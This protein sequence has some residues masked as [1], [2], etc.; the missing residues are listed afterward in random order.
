MCANL[1]Q[2]TEEQASF[3]WIAPM[4]FA[5]STHIAPS[6]SRLPWPWVI[7]SPIRLAAVWYDRWLARQKLAELDDHL[8][9]DIGMDRETLRIE[10]SKPFWRA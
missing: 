10:I 9:R 6:I 7:V 3:L 8:L 1:A 4:R 5:N 2:N